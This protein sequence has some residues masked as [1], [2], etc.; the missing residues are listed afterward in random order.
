MQEP[1]GSFSIEQLADLV[2]VPVRTIRYYITEGLLPG[3]GSR[4][5][6]ATYRADHL[7]RLRLIRLLT[8]R[9]V[10][11]HEIRQVLDNLTPAEVAEM[12][13]RETHQTQAEQQARMVPKAFVTELLNRSRSAQNTTPRLPL[14][15]H[16][17]QGPLGE[18]LLPDDAQGSS[19][20]HFS[21]APGL[22]LQVQTEDLDQYRDLIARIIALVR[23]AQMP[24]S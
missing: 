6:A 8:E 2:D 3:P 18:S 11:L 9:R 21:L 4:G 10:P 23:D 13:A 7:V 17:R 16:K 5:K 24:P 19:R 22:E 20:Q 1:E 12:L 14:R 15:D